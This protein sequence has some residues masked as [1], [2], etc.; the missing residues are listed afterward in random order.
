MGGRVWILLGAA[1]A[2]IV[3]LL[4]VSPTAFPASYLS[5][6]QLPS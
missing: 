4:L 3:V 1:I 2:A 5:Q 6:P